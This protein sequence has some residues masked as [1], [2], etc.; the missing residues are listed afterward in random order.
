MELMVLGSG[1]AIPSTRRGA[2]GYLVRVGGDT[3]VMD[4]G[5]G[6]LTRLLGAGVRHD[7][8]SHVLCTHTHLDHIGEL[9]HW[10]FLSRI[11]SAERRAPLTLVGSGGVFEMIDG[12]RRVH[13]DWLDARAYTRTAITLDGGD[14]ATVEFAGWRLRAYPVNHI[15]SSL[16]F[17]LTD[18]AGRRLA[19]TGDSDMCDDLVELARGV[20]LLVIESSAPDGQKIPGHLT[21]S[22]AGEVA[23]RAGARRVMLTHFYPPCDGV[24]MLGQLRRTFDGDAVLAADGMTVTV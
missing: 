23:R 10:L 20:D 12:L 24:D 13:G 5:P 16:A 2:P 6:T 7:D 21:P 9:P 15:P 8:V 19:Y 4:C 18:E 1:T 3:V 11:P 22:E 17:R 14:R